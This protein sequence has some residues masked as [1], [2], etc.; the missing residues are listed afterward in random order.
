MMLRAEKSP[1][2]NIDQMSGFSLI[3]CTINRL[4]EVD[5]FLESL[6]QQTYKKFEVIVVD[7]NKHNL[8]DEV[9]CKW[10]KVLAIKHFKVN[11]IGLSRARN[12]GIREASNNI[13]GFPDDD[14]KYDLYTLENVIN[15]FR[16][17]PLSSIVVGQLIADFKSIEQANLRSCNSPQEIS[18]VQKL[19][20]CKAIS[21]LIFV[22]HSDL[23][24][25]TSN[26]FDET[27]G[28]GAG[29][30]WGSGEETDFLIRAFKS[31]LKIH[32]SLVIQ[33]VH[34]IQP[35]NCIQCFW[36]GTG[37]YRII[38]KNKLGL[39][40][41]MINI[42]QPFVRMIANNDYKYCVSYCSTALGRS[43]IIPIIKNYFNKAFA[44]F[45]KGYWY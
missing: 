37:R 16:S 27:L 15:F 8:I 35:K 25:M 18:S 4:N 3:L 42:L 13:I 23:K 7:Q 33:V 38:K 10:S 1:T 28:L 9:V 24:T 43:G 44:L 12:Y 32:Q 2:E 21:F 39:K 45:S 36:Y 34:S 29:T 11:F 40:I 6:S 26:F 19:F 41:Y 14:C 31:G 22:K 5:K 30:Q 17:E 20:Q